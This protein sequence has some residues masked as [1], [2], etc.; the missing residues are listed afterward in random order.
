MSLMMNASVLPQQSAVAVRT[1]GTHLLRC[2]DR[3]NLIQAGLLKVDH[4]L[5]AGRLINLNNHRSAAH[6]IPEAQSGWLLLER[7]MV[8]PKTNVLH[9]EPVPATMSQVGDHHQLVVPGKIPLAGRL[10]ARQIGAELR[11]ADKR[12][13]QTVRGER[14]LRRAGR[15]H[16]IQLN[17][18]PISS[19]VADGTSHQQRTIKQMHR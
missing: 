17:R 8:G 19:A 13:T 15:L 10:R 18:Q 14:E 3:L 11:A 12:K 4:L 7:R 1:I 5:I 6:R 2:Q 16:R 9:A